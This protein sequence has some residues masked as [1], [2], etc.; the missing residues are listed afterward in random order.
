MNQGTYLLAQVESSMVNLI[1]IESG[2]R[3]SN[4]LI[5][6]DSSKIPKSDF[7]KHFV[8]PN[9]TQWVLKS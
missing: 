1:G 6:A 9:A 7:D 2:N 5:V 8:G 4:V 3:W